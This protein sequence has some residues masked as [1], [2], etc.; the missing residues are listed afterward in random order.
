MTT[1][2]R[3][4]DRVSFTQCDSRYRATGEVID[5]E[6]IANGGYVPDYD[7]YV[8]RQDRSGWTHRLT[9]DNGALLKASE[10]IEPASG[11]ALEWPEF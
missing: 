1:A 8:V 2:I 7:I 10:D 9:I 5:I 6:H 4:G 3:I 11:P